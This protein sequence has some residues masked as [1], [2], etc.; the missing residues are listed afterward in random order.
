[1]NVVFLLVAGNLIIHLV[2]GLPAAKVMSVKWLDGWFIEL[3]HC[4]LCIGVWIFFVIN[5]LF[6][7]EI[8]S[9][10]QVGYI[11]VVSEA[12]TAA[13]MS[14]V[15]FIFILGLKFRYGEFTA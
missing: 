14:W 4:P 3:F 6:R 10:A 1:M 15:S 12:I 11:P 9:W 2:L 8:T 7:F 5:C 13:I